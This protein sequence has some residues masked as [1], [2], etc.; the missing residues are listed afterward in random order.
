MN[1]TF[2]LGD[3]NDAYTQYFSGKS[4]LNQL[5]DTSKVNLTVEVTGKETSN[6]WCEPVSDDDYAKLTC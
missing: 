5:E 2:G 3:P 4:F 6:E 1:P